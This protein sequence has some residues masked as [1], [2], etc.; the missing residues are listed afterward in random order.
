MFGRKKLLA[1]IEALEAQ[2]RYLENMHATIRPAITW[3]TPV[4][5]LDRDW[6]DKLERVGRYNGRQ[7]TEAEVKFQ[8][9]H[10]QSKQTTVETD[11]ISKV[12]LE[13]LARLVIDG[14]P[15][16]RE[17]KVVSKRISEYTEDATIRTTVI[18]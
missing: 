7:L 18:E 2:V 14:R 3:E 6:K 10:P 16:R 17:E 4:I 13:E 15:I 8:P 5:H 1:R 9:S 11:R 12:T